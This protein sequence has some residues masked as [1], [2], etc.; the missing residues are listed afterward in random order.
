MRIGE[1]RSGDEPPLALTYTRVMARDAEDLRNLVASQPGIAAAQEGKAWRSGVRELSAAQTAALANTIDAAAGGVVLPP[2]PGAAPPSLDVTA[3][4]VRTVSDLALVDAAKG[5]ATS[6]GVQDRLRKIREKVGD[7]VD[8][9][10]RLLDGLDHI[11]ATAMQCLP[12]PVMVDG[13]VGL[14]KLNPAV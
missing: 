8:V 12:A 11:E 10:T 9:E 14:Y 7:L 5:A 1:R 4:A 13:V 3:T 6:K 2:V